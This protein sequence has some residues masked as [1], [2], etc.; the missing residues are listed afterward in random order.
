VSVLQVKQW[1]SGIRS[2]GFVAALGF[3][4]TLVPALLAVPAVTAQTLTVLYTFHGGPDGAFPTS[5]LL[6]DSAGQLYGTTDDGGDPSCNTIFGVGCGTIFR[7]GHGKKTVL[8][9]GGVE[10]FYPL[11]GLV[12]DLE[13]HGYGTTELGGDLACNPPSGCGVAFSI[14]S[15][16]NY[17][18]LHSFAG[19]PDGS[20]PQTALIRD[21][22]GNLYGTTELGGTFLCG[23]IGC[24]TVFKIDP[25]GIETVLYNFSGGSDGANP[26]AG[27]AMDAH[28]NLYGTA[29]FGGDSKCLPP[30]GCGVVFKI[31]TVGNFKVVH[32]FGPPPDGSQPLAGLVGD[33]EGNGYGTTSLGGVGLGT[34][35]KINK[36]G[37]ETVLYAFPYGAANGGFPSNGLVRDTAGNLYGTASGGA[38]NRGVIF[39][40]DPSGNFTLVYNFT[41]GADG[42]GPLAD[43]IID[44]VG[45]LYGDTASG[46]DLTCN[47]PSGCG[48]VFKLIPQSID[49]DQRKPGGGAVARARR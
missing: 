8:F 11:A 27:L 47:P 7:L 4:A 21:V 16:G 10:G 30:N 31:Y 19:K 46:G 44:S 36:N 24:G 43:L 40:L 12:G 14:D 2:R 9:V 29:V 6:R 15:G 18:V 20:N 42:S 35:F 17:T 34:V 3:A 22:A 48:V 37:Q 39:R 1:I 32:T 49:G 33:S 41:G 13:G 25:T 38:F 23:G 28:V 26:K 45:A 5:R